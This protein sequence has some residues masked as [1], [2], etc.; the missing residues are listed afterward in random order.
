MDVGPLEIP[1]NSVK[2]SF[3]LLDCII[4]KGFKLDH[5]SHVIPFF[6]RLLK[7]NLCI[8]LFLLQVRDS[9][10]SSLHNAARIK[11]RRWKRAADRHLWELMIFDQGNEVLAVVSLCFV[12]YSFI[13]G[14][15]N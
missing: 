15:C 1:S 11:S 3:D 4:Q 6:L 14:Y 5:V 12:G 9:G 10:Q 7:G 8:V 13:K 2:V